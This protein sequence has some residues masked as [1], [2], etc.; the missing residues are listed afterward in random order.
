MMVSSVCVVVPFKNAQDT[1]EETLRSIL[2]ESEVKQVVLVNDRSTDDS[3][4][5]VKAVADGRVRVLESDGVG[6]PAALNTALRHVEQPYVARCDADDFLEP[7]RFVDQLAF[8][9]A[10][11][12]FSAVAGQYRV[13]MDSGFDISVRPL[14]D[15][16]EEVTEDLKSGRE[17]THL[18][19]FLTRYSVLAEIGGARDFFISSQDL[20][21][22]FRIAHAGRVML[23]PQVTYVYRLREASISH[24]SDDERRKYYKAKACEYAAQRKAYGFD[25]IDQGKA[26]PF[27]KREVGTTVRMK[28]RHRASGLLESE[29]FW[30]I[31]QRRY[32]KALSKAF[33]SVVFFPTRLSKWRSFFVILVR[34]TVGRLT[35]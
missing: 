35:L 2:R 4:S 20:D 10:N 16:S 28:T 1:V 27:T 33:L 9:Q 21:L 13:V 22:Q 11:R 7:G 30:Q 15:D 12:S 17:R 26:K 18:G 3:V 31:S 23:F 24:S 29:A 14:I 6:I 5:R 25:D 19:T 8:L 34:S 32:A